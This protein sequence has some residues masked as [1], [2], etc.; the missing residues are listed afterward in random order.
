ML[1]AS[2][3]RPYLV[4]DSS[5]VTRLLIRPSTSQY[6]ELWRQWESTNARI[7]AP[8]LITFEVTNALWQIEKAAAATAADTEE[9]LQRFL[10]LPIELVMLPHLH[11]RALSIARSLRFGATN[12]AHFLALAEAAG[13]EAWTS[14]R[15]LV[16]GVKSRFPWVKVVEDD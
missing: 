11:Q 9:L 10:D 7:L 5:F 6:A 8:A 15:R 3:P 13:C 16:N 14:D 4:V 2:D 1:D 12:D